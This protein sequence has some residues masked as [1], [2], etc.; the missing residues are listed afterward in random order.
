MSL[1]IVGYHGTNSEN[2]ES[3]KS[4]NFET[5]ENPADWLGWGVYF[6]VEGISAPQENAEIWA[7]NE[8]YKKSYEHF[9]VLEAKISTSGSVL[10]DATVNEGLAA[11]NKVREALIEKHDDHFKRSR[12]FTCDDRI[13]W[14]LVA[15]NMNLDMIKHNL[16]IKN[17]KQR[18]KKIRSNTPNVTVLCVKRNSFIDQS[19]IKVIKKGAV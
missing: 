4:N 11:Y 1:E 8:G 18:K 2:V 17:T 14:N 15:K 10:L 12:D 13:M 16:Y 9:S 6:F 3:I 19:S 7:K 5:S